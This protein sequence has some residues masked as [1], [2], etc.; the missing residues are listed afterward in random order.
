MKDAGESEKQ[1]SYGAWSYQ[2]DNLPLSYKNLVYSKWKRSYRV[3]NDYIKL[4]DQASFFKAY[5]TYIWMILKRPNT[6]VRFAA[7]TED[8][9]VVLGFAVVELVGSKLTLHYVHVH[10]D[11]RRQGIAS[12]LVGAPQCIERFTHLTRIGLLLWPKKLPDAI[13]D[14]FA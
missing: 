9:D 14:P 13:F 10:K 2:Y 3:G 11:Q 5:D 1:A 6:W 7:L 8:Q 12:F 4:A